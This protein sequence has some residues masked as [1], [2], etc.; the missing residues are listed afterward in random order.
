MGL[1]MVTALVAGNMIG[2]GVF[3]LPAALAPYGWNAV[4]GWI[5]T[6]AGA[7][8][9]ALV[10]AKL[11][12]HVPHAGGPYAYTQDAFGP[13]AGFA[14][15]WAYWISLWVGNAGL[16]IGAVSY[17][18]ALVPAIGKV[19]G[20]HA[21]VTLVLVWTLVALNCRGTRL[22][23]GLQLVTT[24]L[25]L[26]P[27]AAVL[28]LA[29]LVWKQ[30]GAQSLTPFHP[31]DLNLAAMGAAGALTLWGLLGLESATIPSDK[32]D[33]PTR[34]IPR[35]TL[36]GTA[37]TGALYLT[38]CSAV[39]LMMPAETLARSNAPMAD[40]IGRY[41]GPQAAQ[42]IAL[43]AAISAIGALNGWVMLQGEL[44]QAMARGGVFPAWFAKASSRD[45]PVRAHLLSAG[46][47]S[48]LVVINYSQS[49]A[50]V[51][52]FM[53]LLST[54]ASLFAYLACCLAL[55]RLQATG[56][57][58]RTFGLTLIALLA[59]LYS[60]GAVVGAGLEAA[61]WGIV[62][63]FAG[64]PVHLVMRRLKGSIL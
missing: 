4:A 5:V 38:V 53:V 64:L 46:L 63:L 61:L 14:V 26:L 23:G 32:V 34:T 54:T 40:F 48:G 12:T 9:L 62:L 52:I 24:G 19:P 57:I 20:L 28:V 58:P 16:A 15:A 45:T 29:G 59:G 7:L 25:K 10:F 37:F 3:L 33:N 51:F 18:S 47:L 42:A 17:L 13:T 31:Q 21:L 43:F 50:K 27:L 55:L 49:M 1:W 36:I 35:A 44:P 39:I 30:K 11:A 41:W 60:V 6:I 56:R 22:A 8:C 2:A